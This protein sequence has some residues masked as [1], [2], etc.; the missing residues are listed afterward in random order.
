MQRFRKI[1]VGVDLATSNRLV[2]S[3]PYGPSA[4][5][6]RRAIW[7]AELTQAHVSFLYSLDAEQATE[8]LIEE[9]RGDQPNILEEASAAMLR[10]VDRAQATKV[11]A[12]AKVTMGSSW[13]QLVR[14]AVIGEYDLVIVGTRDTGPLQRVLVGSTA[15]K[16]LRKCPCPVWVTRPPA[17]NPTQ[18]IL[19]AHD[20]TAVGHQALEL[21]VSLSE[22]TGGR[23]HILHALQLPEFDEAFPARIKHDDLERRK[24]DAKQQLTTQATDFGLK[25]HPD[26]SVVMGRPSDAILQA[27]DRHQIELL[28]MGTIARTGIRGLLMGN[29]AER[30]MPLLPCSVLAIKPKGFECPLDVDQLD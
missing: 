2:C 25:S 23:L 11:E 28:V 13:R 15:M 20:L 9:H 30:L 29:T 6:V 18:A 17:P 26:I 10:L 8:R 1:L 21:G 24:A 19:V 16:L 12:T 22:L 5:A 4:E 3:E 27:I 7:L 14:Q